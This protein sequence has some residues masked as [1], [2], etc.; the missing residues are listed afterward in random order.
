MPRSESWPVSRIGIPS[1]SSEAN[2]SDSACA[3]MPRAGPQR[4]AALLEL[5]DQLGVDRE[6]VRNRQQLLV[7][8]AQAIAGDGGLD[9]RR[10][11]A[12]ELVLARGVLDLLGGGDPGLELPM[13]VGQRRPHAVGH[14]GRFLLGDDALLDQLLGEQLAHRRMLLDHLVHLRLGVGRL[15][16]LVVTEAA[17]TDQVDQHVMPELL[18]EREGQANGRD[19]GGDIVA[20]DVND[21]NVV[22]LGEIRGPGRGAA[23]SGS[24]VKPT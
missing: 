5:L 10:G 19:A 3:H 23:S 13:V 8:H 18:A 6:A 24:V 7:E 4:I 16:G 21:R 12:V 15:V 11:G 9:L 2:A 14:L 1:V 20:V 22:A 17:V